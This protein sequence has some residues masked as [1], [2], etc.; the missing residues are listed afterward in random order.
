MTSLGGQALAIPGPGM[1]REQENAQVDLPDL[2]EAT[3]AD[4]D[5]TA[6]KALTLAP[7]VPVDPYDPKNVTPWVGDTGKATLTAE[8]EPGDTVPLDKNLP[9]AIGVPEGTDPATLAG[10]WTVGLAAPEVSQDAGVSGLVMKVTPPATVD[11]A[12]QVS[13]S[14][15]TTAFA[16]LYG[17]Q[18]AD[19]FGLV[20]LPECVYSSPTEGECADDGGVEPMAGKNEAD[21]F[22][23]LRSTVTMVAPK[24]APTRTTA[25]KNAK[26]RKI[27]TG[28]VPVAKLLDEGTQATTTSASA[29]TGALQAADSSGGNSVGLLDTGSSV[30]G[31]FTASP[32]LSSGSWSAGSSSGAFTYSYQV[33]TPETAGGLMPK[34]AL[35]YSS[36]SVDGRTS[37]TNNQASWIGDGWDYNAGSITRTYVN[38]RQDS[39][40]AGS[41]NATHR[42][43]DLCYGSENATLSLGGTTTE[44]V[45]DESKGKWFTGNGD[46]SKIE[47]VTG[48]ATGNG[49]KDGEYWVVTTKDGTKY[50]FGLNKLPGWS[51]NGTAA[52]DPT[53]DSVLT[54]PVYGNHAGEPCYKAGDWAH[55]YCTQGWRWS[56]DYVEDVHGNAM[57]L[58]WKKDQNYYARNFNFKAPV[59]YDR[60]GYLSHIYYGQRKDSIFSATAPAR[61]GFEVKER[62]YDV[63]AV[64]C[65][66]TN[67]KSK[68]PGDYRIWFDTP[69][70]LRCESGK[71]CWNAGPTFW[72]RKRLDKITTSAQRRTD[73]TARQVVDEYQLNQSF[74]EL[75]TGPN[76]ALWLESIQRTGYARNGSTDASVKLNSVRFESNSDDMPNRVLAVNPQRPGFSR[77][78]IARVIN[79]YG[80]ETVVKY[81]PITGKCATG[82]LPGKTDTAALKSNTELCYPSFWNPDPEVEDIDWFHKY[83]VASIEELPNIE[84]SF[85]TKTAYEYKNAGWKFADG[86]FTKKSTRTYSQFAGFEQTTVLTGPDKAAEDNGNE[87]EGIAGLDSPRTKAVTRYFRGLGDTVSVKDITGTE[88]AKDKEPFAG[89]VAEELTYTNATDADTNWLTRSVTVPEATE[90]AKRDRDDGLDPLKAWRVTE[91]E[92]IAYTKSSGTGDDTRTLRSVRTLTTYESTY[93]L[94][95]QVES[96]GDTGK[97]GD[98]SCTKLEYLHQTTAN[99]IGLSKQVLTSPTTCANANWS[100]LTTLNSAA[101]TAFDGTAYGTALGASTRGL[102]TESWSL[103]GDGTGFETNGTTGFDAIGRVTRQTDPDQKSS[104]ITFDPPTGQVFKVTQTNPLG[105]SQVQELEPGRA[106]TL[107]TTDLNGQ[108]SE[109]KFDPLGRLAEAW[110]PGRTPSSSSVPDFRA[111]YTIPAEE[112]DPTDANLKIRKPPYVTT[113][114]RGHEDRIETSVTLYD[115]LGRERQTQEEPE[116][117]S[118]YLVTDTLYNTSGEVFQTNNAYLTQE[119]KPGELFVPLSDTAIPNITRYTYDGLGRVLQETPYMKYVDPVTKESS[120]KAYEDR[121]TKYE[122]GQDWSKV[123]NPQGASS[124]R[125]YTDALGR[126]SRTDTFNPAAPGGITS[127]S[128]Q[129]D[130][131]GQ[132]VKATKSAD[133]THPW[134]WTYDHRGRMETSTDPDSGTTRT[135]YDH[136]DRVQSATNGRGVTLWTG[137]DDLSRPKQQRMN[138]ANGTVVAD[139]TYDTVAG[140]KGLPA[141]ATRYTDGQAYTQKI[142]GYTKDYQPTSTTLSLP[143]TIADTWGLAKDYTYGYSYTDTGLLEEAQLPAVGKFAAEKMVV[144]YNKEGLPLSISGKDWYGAE[145]VYS[146]YGQMIRSTLGAQPYRVWT[147]NSFDES[148]GELKDQLVFR[149]KSGAGADTSVVG[150]NLVSNRSY[151]YD[152]AGNVTSIREQSVGIEERQCFSYDPLGQLKTAWTS[153]DQTGC[154]TPKNA[155]GTLNVAAGKDSS[156]YWQ[157][158]E[159]DLLGNRTKLTEKDLTGA[160]AKDATTDYAYGKNAAK[161]QPH[162]LTKVT[163][164]FTT[165]A[166]AQVTAEAQRLYELTGETKSITSLQ[167]GD[168]QDLTWTFDGQVDR[169]TGQ[170][171]AGKTPYVGLGQKCL[172]LKSGLPV[173][174]QPIQL[175]GCNATAAQNFRFTPTPAQADPNLGTLAVAENWCFQPA[176]NTAGSAV[177]VQKC[178]GTAAQQLKRNTAG[179]LT[180]VASGLCVAVQ[181][182]ANV[183]GTA[184]VLATCDGA[185]AAQLWAPQNDTR[186]IY[187]PDGSRLLT[188]KGKQATLHLGEAEV[189]VQQGGVLVNTQRT[190]SAPGG[191]VMRYAYGTGSE[192]LVAQTG[193]HQGSTY[194]EVALYGGMSVRIRKQDAF[195]NERGT[196]VANLQSH[197]GF[198]G[199]TEDDASGYTMLGARLYDPV[200]GRFLSADPIVDMNDPL[201]SN[202]Y[203]YA[204]N[205]PV[206]HADPTG[207]AISLTASERAAALAGAGLSAAQVAQAQAMQGKSLSSVILAIAWETLKDFIG[208]NDAMACFGGDMWSCGSI[209]LDAIPWTKLGKIPSVLK[210]INRTINAIQAF[211]AAKKAA[212]IVL[213]AAKAAEAAALKAKK[214]AIEKA[215]K[216]AAQRAKKKAAEQAKRTAD[217]ALAQKKK[218]GNPV[219]KRAQSKA[220]PKSSSMGGGAGKRGGNKVNTS[221]SGGSSGGSS[222]NNGG[223]SGSGDSGK[224]GGSCSTSSNSFTPGTKV[225]MAD[226]TT[227]P[228]EKVKP[229]DK[230]KVT[231]AKTGE[232]RTETVTATIKGQG[233]KHLVKVTIDTDGKAGS[234]TAQVTATD[235]H[236]FWV[237]E[238]GKWIDAGDLKSGQWLQPTTGARVQIAAIERWTT[239]EAT[240]HNLTV[241][242]VHTYYVMAENTPVLVH[243]SCGDATHAD[244][245]YC[246]WG[247]PAVPR[248]GGG[249][250]DDAWDEA[251]S[252]AEEVDD[253]VEE[254]ADH[255]EDL[256]GHAI[257]RLRERGVSEADARAV[258]E[259]TPFSYWHKGQWKSGFYDPK[260]KVFVGKTIDGAINTIMVEVENDYI[261]RIKKK[262]P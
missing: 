160:T 23:R 38:C 143:Q 88:I 18:A 48:Q 27:L 226:G 234:K 166:G 124:Y 120:S 204:H 151:T 256:T 149:E 209:I 150:G 192:T 63:G 46:G 202:G 259:R 56:L 230:V 199:K 201:Q 16:D 187:G 114:A 104:T 239:Q 153:K 224:A 213:K 54:V 134:T 244:E 125:V 19:R 164:K 228:I 123:I 5:S 50:H 159:Y 184:I 165:P 180:H 102:A 212:E 105:H 13:L 205:N 231:D 68:N 61:I 196:A 145:T 257:Q 21:S 70:D 167:S 75:K 14:V 258:L 112:T 148:S 252:A 15:D 99:L 93:G 77:L 94:P 155:D 133:P 22:E 236:P 96:F 78:R 260:S 26:A 60:D 85:G 243:N 45:W 147:Q 121:A 220:A 261:E 7:E 58:W 41:N 208:I 238:L 12:A 52:D 8:T 97:T 222:R 245:C 11:P 43:A 161:D 29:R 217:R 169:I 91:P 73:T 32:L 158:Y 242:N 188:I 189:T 6:E 42:T 191:A 254:V 36:Q 128:Y 79:E 2:P 262:R 185:S 250:A 247:Q 86:E 200:V 156:G 206:T 118:G 232:T 90:L 198:L 221:K 110:A 47:R 136:R 122:Y 174:G 137:Y 237:P 117:G 190:Y 92:E 176:A 31:D 81:K 146:P 17:P 115:G 10:E 197:K 183:S 106:V 138:D 172:D 35:S 24:D 173:A 108:V 216:E 142:N 157:E 210:A 40:K 211:K 229:G 255:A 3:E 119:A 126:T 34:V 139:Y 49:A 194:A 76:T 66:E 251:S 59:V 107:K 235:G 71:K 219:Q 214:L 51:D 240:V 4:G 178:N 80:G 101:R 246:N 74:A 9:I 98:E 30:Q 116:S 37:S 55:S 215:K 140:G 171:S 83:V 130:T 89:R 218:T 241:G 170:G 65:T 177:Q 248:G 111:V 69:A 225:L 186:H 182:A 253:V 179:Q 141:T 127:T 28:T 163:K 100:D 249:S 132:M 152:P 135:T 162:T 39:K 67:F 109:A 82:G 181:G 193:D 223:S 95:T 154:T 84:G 113:Y 87:G 195:G 64:T 203:A 103:K 44:L 175:Y 20:L 33:Q 57:S 168:K 53:T 207:L 131:R 25:A 62:C 129:Y 144:R 233:L 227:K 72:T 1:S